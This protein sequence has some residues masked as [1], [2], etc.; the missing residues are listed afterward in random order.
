MVSLEIIA[1]S[2]FVRFLQNMKLLIN[3]L[4][5]L[6]TY[7]S[8]IL[9]KDIA[10]IQHTI[11]IYFLCT[12]FSYQYPKFKVQMLIFTISVPYVL[13]LGLR[14][15]VKMVNYRCDDGVV[16]V[17][18]HVVYEEAPRELQALAGS[19]NIMTFTWMVFILSYLMLLL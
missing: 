6:T 12:L 3:Y 10:T 16:H 4:L 13:Y 1:Q 17:L 19:T 2:N 9:T 15:T 11:T 5:T 8:T 7:Y 18:D 14:F